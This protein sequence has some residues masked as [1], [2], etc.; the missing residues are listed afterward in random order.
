MKIRTLAKQILLFILAHFC[1]MSSLSYAGDGH[2]QRFIE[3]Y[4]SAESDVMSEKAFKAFLQ[5]YEICAEHKLTH[6]MKEDVSEGF[7]KQVGSI[8]SDEL[9]ALLKKL[10]ATTKDP[11]S[12]KDYFYKALLTHAPP[13]SKRLPPQMFSTFKDVINKYPKKVYAKYAYFF[14][15]NNYLLDKVYATQEARGEDAANQLNSALN[16]LTKYLE[17]YGKNDLLK[18]YA[19]LKLVNIYS[20]WI[21]KGGSDSFE[22]T[23]FDSMMMY[24]EKLMNEYPERKGMISTVLLNIGNYYKDHTD[25]VG[26]ALEYYDMILSTDHDRRL[27][28][29]YKRYAKEYKKFKYDEYAVDSE[30][31]DDGYKKNEEAIV[32]FRE[33]YEQLFDDDNYLLKPLGSL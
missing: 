18:P 30:S 21:E 11:K 13:G 22:K 14:L 27:F 16:V 33:E 29:K 17:K 26:Y 6:K 23:T 31:K 7:K 3:L 12:A 2:E 9:R 24:S 4:E 19:Y 8:K 20:V 10:I 28:R 15:A 25:E 5:M 32:K 1:L